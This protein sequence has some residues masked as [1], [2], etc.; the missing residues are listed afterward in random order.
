MNNNE[1]IP[2]SHLY[3]WYNRGVKLRPR[4]AEIIELYIGA[5][6]SINDLS[7]KY[8]LCIGTI[9]RIISMYFDQPSCNLIFFSN[10]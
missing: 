10:A 1:F 6:M 8:G 2:E 3:S 9:C 5:G 7:S 4:N